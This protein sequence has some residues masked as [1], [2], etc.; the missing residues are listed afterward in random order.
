MLAAHLLGRNHVLQRAK[1]QGVEIRPEEADDFAEIPKVIPKEAIA[2]FK[3][4][5]RLP[6][7]TIEKL[8]AQLKGKS[9]AA[10]KSLLDQLR[11]FVDGELLT[12]LRAGMDLKTFVDNIQAMLVRGGLGTANPFRLET[13]FRTNLNQAYT[14]GRL[15]QIEHPDVAPVFQW[16]QYNA[17]MDSRVRPE[18]AAM[19]GKV[20]RRDD[21]IWK[22]WMPPN[23]YN[24]RCSVTPVSELDRKAEGLNV[25]TSAPKI[26]GNEVRPDP[27]FRT[28][29]AARLRKAVQ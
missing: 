27:G 3:N 22:T 1:A 15:A 24:C 20:F 5:I 17:I 14:A 21:P 9:E 12:A 7:K 26:D 13:I 29:P 25:S 23:G 11:A 8:V 18:H 6:M 28:N 16:L 10:I 2:F 19:N 4:R